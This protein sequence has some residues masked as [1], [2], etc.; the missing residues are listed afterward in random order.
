MDT[1]GKCIKRFSVARII[2]EKDQ[3]Y[4]DAVLMGHD[5]ENTIYMD[6][7]ARQALGVKKGQKN[8][9][10]KLKKLG[11]FCKIYWYLRTP[12]PRIHTP[13]RLAVLLAIL[14][15]LLEILCWLF[16]ILLGFLGIVL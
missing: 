11:F 1:D 6:F 16:G 7:D 13:A 5:N 4:W 14:P 9:E 8:F 12:D 2:N 3:S 15:W 10:F